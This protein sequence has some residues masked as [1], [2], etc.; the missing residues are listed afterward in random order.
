MHS[1]LRKCQNKK[2]LEQTRSLFNLH[3]SVKIVIFYIL[4]CIWYPV[5]E[6]AINDV[7]HILRFLTPLSPLPPIL[8][9][10]LRELCHFLADPPSPK[11]M[12]SFIDGPIVKIYIATLLL[13]IM[14]CSVTFWGQ[15]PNYVWFLNFKILLFFVYPTYYIRSIVNTI[16]L[17]EDH[18]S[19]KFYV[20]LLLH[21]DKKFY[22]CLYDSAQSSMYS[23]N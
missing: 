11:W 3:L 18:V 1:D 10:R 5:Q 16:S 12:T 4:T 21:L 22:V 23:W 9:D 6:L 7:T 15:I 2:S 8:L 14:F 19:E 13:L 17:F 20:N